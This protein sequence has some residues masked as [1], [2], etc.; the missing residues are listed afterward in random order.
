MVKAWES[1]SVKST[2]NFS[3]ISFLIIFYDYS[4]MTL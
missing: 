1:V 4:N 3:E 2:A